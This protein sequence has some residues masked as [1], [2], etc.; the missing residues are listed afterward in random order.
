LATSGVWIRLLLPTKPFISQSRHDRAHDSLA[1][2]GDNQVGHENVGWSRSP[3][4]QGS[5]IL[6][7][8]VLR[9]IGQHGGRY[10]PSRS[11]I[12]RAIARERERENHWFVRNTVTMIL[13]LRKFPDICKVKLG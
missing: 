2:G 8:G 12:E 6:L 5:L 11:G 13:L 10:N 9:W 4:A 1:P 7:L 3:R